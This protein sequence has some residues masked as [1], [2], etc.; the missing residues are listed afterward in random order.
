MAFSDTLKDIVAESSQE[1]TKTKKDDLG[2]MSKQTETNL[3]KII[4]KLTGKALNSLDDIK[5][6]DVKDIKDLTTIY[7]LLTEDSITDQSAPAINTNM[8]KFYQV[9]F[10][11]PEGEKPKPKELDKKLDDMSE[12]DI[13]KLIKGHAK[14]LNDKNLDTFG[15]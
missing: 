5:V 10:K 13:D 6:S 4:S 14:A 1:A 15:N 11:L 7:K 9:N 12:D 8:A 3:L 2:E